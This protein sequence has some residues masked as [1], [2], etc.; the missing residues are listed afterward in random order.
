MSAHQAALCGDRLMPIQR[1][2]RSV[3]NG[4]ALPKPLLRSRHRARRPAVWSNAT[5]STKRGWQS[6]RRRSNEPN[7]GAAFERPS[8]RWVEDAAGQ[9][10]SDVL[11][12]IWSGFPIGVDPVRPPSS[13]GSIH[14][15]AAMTAAS[16]A[17]IEACPN[18]IKRDWFRPAEAHVPRRGSSPVR[19]L[20]Q[21]A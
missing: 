4:R 16:G 5:P 2:A 13:W 10:R 12:A 17:L 6:I 9:I 19:Q 11:P 7:T 3:A 1:F 20:S 8:E 18:R 15:D 14:R 21:C